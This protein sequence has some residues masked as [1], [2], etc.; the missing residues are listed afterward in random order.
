MK[1]CSYCGAEYPDDAVVCVVDQTP[2]TAES[3]ATF[4]DAASW[5]PH[6][7]LALALTSGLAAFLICTGIYCVVGRVSLQLF[8]I[9]HPDLVVPPYARDATIMYPS[10][11]RLLMFGF[12]VFTFAICWMRCQKRWQAI[13]VSVIALGIMA[14]TEFVPG[15]LWIVPGMVFGITTNFTLGYYIGSAF[16]LGVGAWL[17]GWFSRRKIQD[18]L[19]VPPEKQAE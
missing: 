10:I 5:T 4:A 9:H 18:E 17:L 11:G 19:H 6:S 16:Q 13:V 2:F 7:P 8:Y 15:F 12:V 1:K 14:L 3:P